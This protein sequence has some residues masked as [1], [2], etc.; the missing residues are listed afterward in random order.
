MNVFIVCPSANC[1]LSIGIA[2]I[3]LLPSIL[4]THFQEKSLVP[5]G[6][7]PVVLVMLEMR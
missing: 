6:S 7:S 2:D 5:A 4:K 1:I 3:P